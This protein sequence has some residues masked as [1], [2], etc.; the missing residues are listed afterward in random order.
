MK[1][2]ASLLTLTAMLC[3]YTASAKTV[4][5]AE[6]P[7]DDSITFWVKE[8]SARCPASSLDKCRG[9]NL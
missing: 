9:S 2:I 6:R 4:V 7:S 3:F 5:A 8:A 1:P